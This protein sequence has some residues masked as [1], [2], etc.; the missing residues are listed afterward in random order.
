MNTGT[1]YEYHHN[2]FMNNVLDGGIMLGLV[3]TI[4]KFIFIASFMPVML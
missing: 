3:Q 4:H 1:E 2:C